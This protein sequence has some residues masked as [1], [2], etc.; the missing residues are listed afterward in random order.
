MDIQIEPGD[1]V[2][3]FPDLLLPMGAAYILDP[4]AFC[5]K[6][7][8]EALIH[9]ENGLFGLTEAGRWESV[10]RDARLKSV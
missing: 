6:R 9:S 10:E 1:E 8:F 5:A 7:G 4:K 3:E 2:E